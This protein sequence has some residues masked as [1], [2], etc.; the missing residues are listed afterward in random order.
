M[1]IYTPFFMFLHFSS[2]RKAWKNQSMFDE[3]LPD[4]FTYLKIVGRYL[5]VVF[6][7]TRLSEVL[8]N[9]VWWTFWLVF[10]H[11]KS[12]FSLLI[13]HN[14]KL[15][16]QDHQR[17][18]KNCFERRQESFFSFSTFYHSTL[19]KY[20]A[21]HHFLLPFFSSLPK[22]DNWWYSRWRVLQVPFHLQRQR[23]Q[24]VYYPWD[25]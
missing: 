10:A 12:T 5:I 25:C 21:C 1:S 16:R 2:D 13:F 7:Q 17:M 8:S 15:S 14:I 22:N 3:C 23:I 11:L 18:K 19:Y 9:N 20:G 4:S 6:C 24:V